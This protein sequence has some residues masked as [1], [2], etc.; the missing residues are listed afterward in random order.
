M[1]RIVEIL[2]FVCQGVTEPVVCRAEDGCEYVVKG[3]YAGRPALIAEWVAGR[4][5]K[6]LELPIPNFEILK[7]DPQLAAYSI[8]KKEVENLGTGLLFGSCRDPSVV[9]IR[10]ADIPLVALDLQARVLAFD[11]WIANPDRTLLDGAGNP[12]LLWSDDRRQMVVIDHNLA[13]SLGLSTFWQDHVFRDARRVWSSAFQED[14]SARFR[15]ALG[16][17]DAIWAELPDEWTDDNTSL[18]YSK[19]E[20]LLSRIDQEAN[21]F[22]SPS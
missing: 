5:G 19:I 9:E 11:W 12:N 17:L 1:Y 16:E 6:L 2:D 20:G 8:K 7:L 10:Q 18:T 14:M 3:K 4:L 21:T 15:G 13:F 22:W